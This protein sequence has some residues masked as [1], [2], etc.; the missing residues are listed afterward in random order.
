[1]T[2]TSRLY[3]TIAHP[4]QIIDET[5]LTIHTSLQTNNESLDKAEFAQTAPDETTII[6]GLGF[7]PPC[8]SSPPCEEYFIPR[9]I[10]S[11]G[12]LLFRQN[13]TFQMNTGKYNS[14]GLKCGGSLCFFFSI[15]FPWHPPEFCLT[16]KDSKVKL[17]QVDSIR[18]IILLR[19]LTC[20]VR[21]IS[22]SLSFLT[23]SFSSLSR[24]CSCSCSSSFRNWCIFIYS[25]TTTCLHVFVSSCY[26]M[27]TSML[28]HARV[29]VHTCTHDVSNGNTPRTSTFYWLDGW[30]AEF[31][32][33]C[34]STVINTIRFSN[35]RTVFS[36]A[37]H[38]K[39]KR[40]K[41]YDM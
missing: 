24:S 12:K 4:P 41:K 25:D 39:E 21:W 2:I 28:Q 6:S 32:K 37:S 1:M 33:M 36:T 13:L 17:W 10:S 16:S 31:W 18:P 22:F 7:S 8:L 19:R 26:R 20:W 38:E 3:D 27:C 23:F 35:L 15:H 34:T 14:Y 9:K 40:I 11:L 29:R 5:K 30:R